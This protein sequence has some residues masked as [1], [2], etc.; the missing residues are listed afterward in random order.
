M[1][2][3]YAC[4]LTK[5]C[6]EALGPNLFYFAKITIKIMYEKMEPAMNR[7]GTK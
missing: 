2:H 4:I 7:F 6:K 1:K 3:L 5:A